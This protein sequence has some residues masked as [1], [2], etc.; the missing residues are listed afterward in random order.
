MRFQHKGSYIK[1]KGIRPAVT[2]CTAIRAGKLK[3]LMRRRAI[4]HCVQLAAKPQPDSS[5]EPPLTVCQ[6]DIEALEEI[7]ECIQKVL[8]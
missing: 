6:L 4:T 2:K 7:P 3:G 5:I 1:L 8:S